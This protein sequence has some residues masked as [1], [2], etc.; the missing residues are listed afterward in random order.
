MRTLLYRLKLGASVVALGAAATLASTA[1][2]AQGAPA[3]GTSSPNELEEV[4]VT[5][6][7]IRGVAPVGSNLIAVGAE[8]LRATGGQTVTMALQTVPALSGMGATGQGGTAAHYQPSIHSLGA[9]ASNST[10]VL[11]DG[12]RGPTGGT[13]HTFLDPNIIPLTMLERIEVL[14]EGAS[15]TYGSDAVAGVI[16]FITRTR[17][18]GFQVNAQALIGDGY[19]GHNFGFV[20]G[21]TWDTGS[22]IFGAAYTKQGNLMNKDRQWTYPDQRARGGTNFLGFNCSPATIQ[23]GGTGPIF[24]NATSGQSVTNSAANAPC[25]NWHYT[26]RVGEEVRHNVMAKIRQDLTEDL[27]VGLD[28][29]YGRRRND[30]LTGAGTVQ[31]TVF[32][33][34]PQANPFYTNPVGYTGTATR[35]TI[36]WDA[37][38]LFGPGHNLTGS[39]SMYASFTAAYRINDNW[40]FDFLAAAGRDVSDSY[41][42]GVINGS[43]ANLA[44]NGTTNSGGNTTAISVPGTNIVVTQLP[45]TV[46]NA[47]DVW[48]PAGTNRTSAEVRRLLL[49]NANMLENTSGFQQVRGI[50]NGS[51]FNLPAG[52]VK[53]AL[54]AEMLHT[55]LDQFVARANNSGPASAGSQ[56]LNFAFAREVQSYFAEAN[57]PLINEAMGVPLMQSFEVNLSVRHDKYSDFGKTTNPRYAFNW[58]V[59]DGLKIRGNYSTSFVAPPLTI[60]GDEYGAFGTAGW[61]AVTNNVPVPVAAYPVLAQMGIAG[62]TASSTT[63]NISSLE[64]IQ[65][66]S[67]NHFTK[68]QEGK[69]WSLGF[70]YNPTWL[71][72]FRSQVTYW[73]T[74][75]RGGVTGPNLQN[76]INTASAN[77]LLTFYPGCAT[78]AQLAQFTTGIPQRTTAPAC[79]SYIFRS[80]NSNWLNLHVE[81]IDYSVAYTHNTDAM[82]AFTVGVTGTE[83]VKYTQ[84][85]GSGDEYD[86]LNTTGNN[87]TFPSVATQLRGN[88]GWRLNNFSADLFANYTGSYR[89]WSGNSV[90]PITRDARGNPGGGGDEVDANLTWDLNLRYVFEQ[91]GLLSDTEISLAARN[92]FDKVPPFYNNSQGYD[93]FVANPFGRTVSI[94]IQ[95]KF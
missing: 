64:G 37:T 46:A 60:L 63:C 53:I 44:L 23:P 78:P 36:R 24:L 32:G 87:G 85:F 17:F 88:L 61:N 66:T 95:K 19:N 13:N 11:I 83:F 81:G 15:A 22:A 55:Q 76:V 71:P 9:S 70:D 82:G 62:C 25:T 75:F 91:E 49:D 42:V 5:G 51:L 65:V 33:T 35:Q 30:S 21:K 69:G 40:N 68:A 93:N 34:G 72:G 7:S 16:N 39:D 26:D 58:G 3:T 48:N 43:V 59:I 94:A 77:F 90:T 45:L 80:L 92:I 67:G 89:N 6:T 20:T 10:L 79:T 4:V 56:Q 2:H 84:S 41:N 52:A 1:A 86:I 12:H 31:A 27:T 47:L 18:D 50:V 8:D 38:E 73:T 29:V 74:E 54:G 28:M 14:A 57:V